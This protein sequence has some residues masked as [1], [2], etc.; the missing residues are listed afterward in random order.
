MGFDRDRTKSIAAR[1]ATQ[2]VFVGTS[3]WKYP[4]WCGMLY[5]R[6]RYTY[7]DKFAESRFAKQCLAEYAEVFKSV[8]VDAAYYRFPDQK[9]LETL[10]TPVPSDFLFAFKVTDEIT[11]RKFAN[12]PRF[13]PRAGKPNEN[14]LNADLFTS[15]FLKPC[16]PFKKNIGLLMFEFSRFYPTDYRRGRDFVADLDRFLGRLPTGWPYGVE[17][18]N[19]YFLRPEYFATLSRHNVSHVFNSWADMVPVGEQM[20]LPASRSSPDL[21]AARFLLKPGRKYEEAVKFFEPYDR[22]REPNPEA[23]AAGAALI[24]EGIELAGKRKTFVYVN[25]RLEGNALETIA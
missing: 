1:L 21:C 18:R 13:G 22:V 14:F 20:T 23:R 24:K 5:D 4:G 6:G 7:R 11:I 3:S 12:L 19:K 10:V 17:I 25:N 9:Y 15:D 8:C 16:E 2:G